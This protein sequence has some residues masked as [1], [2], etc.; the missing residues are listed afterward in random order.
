MTE[1]MRNEKIKLIS[2]ITDFTLSQ[3]YDPEHFA[4]YIYLRSLDERT[5]RFGDKELNSLL[6]ILGGMSAGEE[7]RY[8][9][10][11]VLEMLR[12]YSSTLGVS[13]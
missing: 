12:S 1:P 5:Y 13:V 4:K 2:E 11:E 10:E 8:S 7:F 9:K 3:P 6:D